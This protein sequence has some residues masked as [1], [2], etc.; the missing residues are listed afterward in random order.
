VEATPTDVCDAAIAE[1]DDSEI[2]V[3]AVYVRSSDRWS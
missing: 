2:R 3:S 1:R